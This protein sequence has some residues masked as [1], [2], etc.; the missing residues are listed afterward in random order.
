MLTSYIAH[1]ATN[2]A[3]SRDDHE[4]I[5]CLNDALDTARAR[6]WGVD[7]DVFW[8]GVEGEVEEFRKKG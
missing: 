8:E 6:P 5:A 2:P 7:L 1:H 4:T 3:K